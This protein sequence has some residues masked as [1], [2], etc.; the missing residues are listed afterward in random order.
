[1]LGGA[2]NG[3]THYLHVSIVLRNA[4]T[5]FLSDLFSIKGFQRT[6]GLSKKLEK[7]DESELEI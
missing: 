6:V 3:D 1:M 4:N 2:L 5:S 7:I